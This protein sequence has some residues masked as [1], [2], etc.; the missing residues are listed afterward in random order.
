MIE[1]N[2]RSIRSRDAQIA[3]DTILNAA[4][5]IFAQNGFYGA[6]INTIV[7]ASGYN[8]SLLFQY[9]KDKLGLYIAVLTRTDKELNALLS[10]V[11][12]PWLSDGTDIC[13]TQ[14]L[15][16]FLKDLIRTT[17]DYLIEHPMFMRILNWEMADGWKTYMQ[18]SSQFS[19]DESGHIKMLFHSAYQAGLLHSDFCPEIQLILILHLCQ[20]FCASL[21]LYQM[22]VR[23]DVTSDSSITSAR[24]YIV[25]LVLDGMIKSPKGV[26]T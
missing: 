8:N 4:E 2:I 7:K 9:F 26:N 14:A 17:F 22:Y 11:M 1:S 5:S 6:R 24:E 20:S 13:N 21:S 3:R 12:A 18:I 16:D 23:E 19:A 15:R 25:S 10:N